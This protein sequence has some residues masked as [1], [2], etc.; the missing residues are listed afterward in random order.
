M[1]RELA[2]TTDGLVIRPTLSSTIVARK[3]IRKFKHFHTNISSLDTIQRKRGRKRLDWKFRNRV[4]FKAAQLKKVR[5]CL[6]YLHEYILVQICLQETVS[7][8]V[9][10]HSTVMKEKVCINFLISYVYAVI[11]ITVE[12]YD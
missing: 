1:A 7:P 4:G 6:L 10:P 9:V 3:A 11:I 2:P 12:S 8:S 5:W